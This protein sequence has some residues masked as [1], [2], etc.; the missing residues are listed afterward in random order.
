MGIYETRPRRATHAAALLLCDACDVA[1]NEI[2][3]LPSFTFD[4]S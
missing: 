2:R 4:Q 3:V 1:T